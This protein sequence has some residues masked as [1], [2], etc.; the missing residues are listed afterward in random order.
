MSDDQNSAAMAKRGL[1]LISPAMAAAFDMVYDE[2]GNERTSSD[3]VETGSGGDGTQAPAPEGGGD[4]GKTPAAAAQEAGAQSGSANPLLAS[5]EPAPGSDQDSALG[6]D[7]AAST[8][9]TQVNTGVGLFKSDDAVPLFAAASQKIREN[10]QESFRRAA[11]EQLNKEIDPIFKTV[12]ETDPYLLVGQS[13]PSLRPDA[14]PEDKDL[15]TDS[16]KA[17]EYK[18]ALQSLVEAEIK[19]DVAKREKDVMPMMSVLQESALMFQNNPDLIPNT[20]KFDQ[21]LAERVA[22]VGKSYELVVNGKVTGYQVNMQPIINE[23]RE[24]LTKERAETGIVTQQQSAQAARAAEQARDEAGKF[25]GP[26]A[27]ITSKSNAS[28]GANDEDNMDGFWGFTRFG[29]DPS[30]NL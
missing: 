18:R 1:S 24:Q 17:A 23:L 4:G 12:L 20:D 28:G 10:M 9:E 15:M 25:R 3:P 30:L 22:R 6:A 11:E 8:P 19:D 7:A 27:G 5:G 21:Q 14:K 13:L 29:A 26:Q 16:A 2:E